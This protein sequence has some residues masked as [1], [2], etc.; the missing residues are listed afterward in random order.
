M[1]RA[2]A[3]RIGIIPTLIEWDTNIPEWRVLASELDRVRDRTGRALAK[4]SMQKLIQ[5]AQGKSR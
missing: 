3:Q 1:P 2:I 5:P 4:A